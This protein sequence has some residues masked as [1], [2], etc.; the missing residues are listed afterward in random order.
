MQYTKVDKQILEEVKE[1]N[2]ITSYP[3]DFQP[4][5]KTV[6]NQSFSSPA[7]QSTSS[8]NQC[9]NDD[10]QI[11][12]DKCVRFPHDHHGVVCRLRTYFID[13]VIHHFL[14][15]MLGSSIEK[16]DMDQTYQL[17]QQYCSRCQNDLGIIFDYFY[18]DIKTLALNRNL[19][20][21]YKKHL[22]SHSPTSAV[23]FGFITG[24]Q[25]WLAKYLTTHLYL[26]V[27]D[28]NSHAQPTPSASSSS[29]N[30]R[31]ILF[32]K[33]LLLTFIIFIMNWVQTQFFG[34]CP[35]LFPVVTVILI[36]WAKII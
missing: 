28:N 25:I 9:I 8:N 15:R 5:P 26:D 14:K 30:Q 32:E 12:I 18:Q 31:I 35:F 4:M 29:S 22:L 1:H 21:D 27:A 6:L 11:L 19:V 17:I 7:D 36:A 3:D 16:D 2:Y 23:R 10:I 24:C 34:S 13:R 33:Y 20:K